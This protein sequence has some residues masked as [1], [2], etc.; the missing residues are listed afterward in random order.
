MADCKNRLHGN[1]VGTNT[2][3]QKAA[4]RET[5]SSGDFGARQ[6]RSFRFLKKIRRRG[7]SAINKVGA[8]KGLGLRLRDVSI[9]RGPC[10]MHPL[11]LAGVIHY[12]RANALQVTPTCSR[13]DFPCFNTDMKL[14]V[15]FP[16]ILLACSS[17]LAAQSPAQ[18]ST[19]A[20]ASE[21][22][23]GMYSFLQ[24]GEFVQITVEDEGHVTGFV[25]RYGD[26]ESDRGAFLDQFFKQ[27]KLDGNKL[28]F[29]TETVHGI[30]YEFK[31]TIERGDGK[32]LEDQ[33]Y[34]V[35]KG[36]LI[37][38]RT[39]ANKKVTSKSQQV[40]LKSFPREA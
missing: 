11:L 21:N 10:I 28:N 19:A 40:I 4:G 29:T 34:Y 20:D 3:G 30:W 36:T 1:G 13:K 32:T 37:E 7:S 6:N 15:I 25:S 31:G 18:G 33:S 38:Y 23:S 39:D 5:N 22:Y 24:D 16:L 26:S 9:S 12:S 17:L 2:S 8:G 27:G 14:A 35:L